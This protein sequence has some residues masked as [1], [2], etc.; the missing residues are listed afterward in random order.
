MKGFIE[1]RH[2]NINYLINLSTVTYIYP[3]KD[4]KTVIVFNAQWDQNRAMSVTI[5][6]AYE[7][8][9]EKITDSLG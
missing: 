1:V 4:E 8:V 2:G 7:T 9:K 6:D 3:F 5:D